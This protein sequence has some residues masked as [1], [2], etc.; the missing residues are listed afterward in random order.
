MIKRNDLWAGATRRV[1]SNSAEG[2]RA[3]QLYS[4]GGKR[5][6]WQTGDENNYVKRYS[7]CVLDETPYHDRVMHHR[8]KSTLKTHF[9]S[10]WQNLAVSTSYQCSNSVVMLTWEEV[11]PKKCFSEV[12][13]LLNVASVGVFWLL[14]L[15]S[16]QTG[17]GLFPSGSPMQHTQYRA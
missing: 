8:L 13:P 7:V 6:V 3:H 9:L 12:P 15:I 4:E 17:T 16:R 11:N 1:E 10:I 2:G 14:C 5:A